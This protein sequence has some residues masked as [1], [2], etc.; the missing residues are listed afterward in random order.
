M[1]VI[2]EVLP[3]T[4]EVKI[5]DIHL[6]PDASLPVE[7]EKLRQEIWNSR[8]LPIRKALSPAA[9]GLS[10]LIKELQRAEIISFLTSLW[11]FSIVIIVKKNGVDIQLCI[12]I[13]DWFIV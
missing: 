10:D 13:T 6:V 11:T 7:V 1:A 12:L 9:R 8:H 5:E 4:E 3:T 2:P